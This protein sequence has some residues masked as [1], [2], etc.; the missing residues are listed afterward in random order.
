[1]AALLGRDY[2]DVKI[3]TERHLNGA[4]VAARLRGDRKGGIPWIVITDEQGIELITSDG[5]EGNIGCPVKP[6]EVEWFGTMIRRT[7]RNLGE[8]EQ[9]KIQQAL[10]AYAEKL[11]G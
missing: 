2:V 11:R 1:M 8:A 7:A 10:E 5:P 6:E 3:D 9:V 4:A